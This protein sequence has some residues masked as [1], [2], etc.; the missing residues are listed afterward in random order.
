M[1]EYIFEYDVFIGEKPERRRQEFPAMRDEDAGRVA[2]KIMSDVWEEFPYAP[3]RI[4]GKL[5]RLEKISEFVQMTPEI[6]AR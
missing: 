3:P 5:Y 6:A 4:S 1:P 2:R